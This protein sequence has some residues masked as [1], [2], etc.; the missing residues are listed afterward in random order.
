MRRRYIVEFADTPDDRVEGTLQG[1]RT[2]EAVPFY[3]W[4]QLVSL[5]EPPP[6]AAS[7]P[8]AE[9]E[10]VGPSRTTQFPSS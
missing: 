2:R 6:V 3:G 10:A 1:L 5:L 9:W 4:R 8:E 7:L